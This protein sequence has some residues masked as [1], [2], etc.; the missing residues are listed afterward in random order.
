MEGNSSGAYQFNYSSI[1]NALSTADGRIVN[2]KKVEVYLYA[3]HWYYNS[4]GTAYLRTYNSTSLPSSRPT[5]GNL[6]TSSSWPKPGGRW[7]NVGTSW[8]SL[9]QSGSA[10]GVLIGHTGTTSARAY[11][12]FNKSAKLRITYDVTE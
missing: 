1:Q 6:V 4:G 5:A 12:R 11:G 2:I 7:V 8:G 9:F 3:N 10:K